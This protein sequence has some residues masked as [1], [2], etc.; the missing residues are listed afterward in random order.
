MTDFMIVGRGLAATCLM[1]AFHKKN[2]TFKVFGDPNLSLSSRVAAGIWNPVVFK[3]LT[4]SWKA[5]K[6]IPALL[7]FYDD[8][9]KLLDCRLIKQRPIIK[10]FT[11]E[12]EK[13]LWKKKS[14]L[15]L[16]GFLDPKIH[17]AG[18]NLQQLKVPNSYGLV[19]QS[20]NLDVK[21]F[22]ESSSVFF[23]DHV[24][25][26]R[27]NYNEL[28]LAENYA[29]YQGVK[30]RNIVFCEGYLV[31]ENP[32]FNWLPLKPAKGEVLTIQTNIQGLGDN[33]FNRNGFL[34]HLSDDH[35]K[36]GATY[37]W[38]DLS[39]E[40]TEAGLMELKSKLKEMTDAPYKVISHEAGIR[41]SSVDRRPLIG[42]HPVHQNLFVF[43]GLGTKGVMLAPYLS[44][45]FV[46]FFLEKEVLLPE[47]HIKRFYNLYDQS[48]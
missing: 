16:D 14:D 23:K 24:T 47:V 39:A 46:N 44:E 29:E 31:G 21:L 4:K 48:N 7:S 32:Y 28:L 27:F 3:R 40:P 34:M 1:H 30:A 2:I 11:E 17:N 9:E 35:F 38:K 26:T 12:Q 37:E 42:P 20:G 8:S 10:P 22:L 43:N 36:L 13:K 33:I 19:L 15:E 25:E 45:N 5:E 41:P 18:R 6:L